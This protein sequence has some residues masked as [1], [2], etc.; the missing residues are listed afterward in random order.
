M[1][2]KKKYASM[3]VFSSIGRESRGN[4]N[5]EKT[6]S[7]VGK[8]KKK[9]VAFESSSRFF[10]FVLNIKIEDAVF[11]QDL[12]SFIMVAKSADSTPNIDSIRSQKVVFSYHNF[13]QCLEFV[14]VKN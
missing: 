2:K 9:K 1:K 7:K 14:I 6:F 4:V 13:R 8:K 3:S 10:L 5:K 11:D 12:P